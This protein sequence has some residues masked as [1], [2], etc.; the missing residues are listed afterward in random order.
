MVTGLPL[1][2]VRSLLKN[3][4]V[5]DTAVAGSAREKAEALAATGFDIAKA[6]RLG[7]WVATWSGRFPP[8][9]NRTVVALFIGT[10]GVAGQG[11]SA[12][13][14]GFEQRFVEHAAAGGAPVSQICGTHDFGLKIFDLALDLPV[15]DITAEAALD[16]RGCAATIAFGMEAVAGGAD[17][18][19][20]GGLGQGG[21]V[22]AAAVL[23]VL[24]GGQPGDWL[25]EADG[26]LNAKRSA[27]AEKALSLHG[28][29]SR[30]PMEALRRLGG[31]EMAAIV[32][33]IL[34]ARTEKV[35]VVLDGLTAL[36]AATILHAARPGSVDHCV[37]ADA[38]GA[39]QARA[40]D[41]LGIDRVLNLGLGS[42]DGTAG[43]MAATCIRDACL[44]LDQTVPL[45]K[46]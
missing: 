10:H 46:G 16:E 35:P 17:L 34:A 32:G 45:P 39:A 20:L 19:C 15:A 41:H 25:D 26:E 13:A 3:L 9:P 14:P 31:R 8:R 12:H 6:G 40:G 44:I 7:G 2:D 23:S 37:L 33:A 21:E 5:A 29:A 22:A 4:P 27:A 36:A 18:M 38:A 11:A 30:D 28:A 1:D 42:G 43:A 24:V